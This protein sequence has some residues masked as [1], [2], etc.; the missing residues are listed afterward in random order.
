[1]NYWLNCTADITSNHMSSKIQWLCG[2]EIKITLLY[3]TTSLLFKLW[4]SRLCLQGQHCAHHNH[5]NIPASETCPTLI[6]FIDFKTKIKQIPS[7]IQW[8]LY[9]FKYHRIVNILVFSAAPFWQNVSEMPL[10]L[11]RNRNFET[12]WP[13]YISRAAKV[14]PLLF[15]TFK[16]T[17]WSATGSSTCSACS[18]EY[19]SNCDLITWAM[20]GTKFR[21]LRSRSSQRISANISGV[22]K[23]SEIEVVLGGI[24]FV[25]Q[26]ISVFFLYLDKIFLS[27]LDKNNSKLFKTD[28]KNPDYLNLC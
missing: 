1:M 19:C 6:S 7:S 23:V 24:F 22:I 9:F 17:L 16:M 11:K 12:L 26:F 15:V 21:G 28:K 13:K 8:F 2:H 20:A 3:T 14:F 4:P 25:C 18:C 5:S 10:K 27:F